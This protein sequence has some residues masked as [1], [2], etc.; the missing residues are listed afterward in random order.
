MNHVSVIGAG[1]LGA[2]LGAA[3]AN[4]G[5]TIKALSCKALSAAKESHHIIGTAIFLLKK[6][7]F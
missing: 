4:K 5:F 1:R 2:S 7:G 6:M 3:L